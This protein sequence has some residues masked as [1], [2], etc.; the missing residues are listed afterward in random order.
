MSSRAE[1]S[2][3]PSPTATVRLSSADHRV[4]AASFSALRPASTGTQPARDGLSPH[5]LAGVAGSARGSAVSAA[6][7]I[8]PS[9]AR[10]GTGR[11]AGRPRP[12]RG[13]RRA[14]THRPVSAWLVSSAGPGHLGPSGGSPG[15][16]PACP[17]GGGSE[18]WLRPGPV[19]GRFRVSIGHPISPR[20]HGRKSV[21][22]RCRRSR[23]EH[24]AGRKNPCRPSRAPGQG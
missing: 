9:R 20:R 18:S 11:Q 5:Q 3:S 24:P 14:G 15:S 16:E 10:P 2:P 19:D 8:S 6:T 4:S 23:R 21:P 13:L 22:A 12:W 7:S 17:Q 1:V